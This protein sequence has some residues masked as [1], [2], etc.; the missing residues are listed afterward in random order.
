[1]ATLEEEVTTLRVGDGPVRVRISLGY[2]KEVQDVWIKPGFSIEVLVPEDA[3]VDDYI[4]NELA[5][6]VR[7]KLLMRKKEVM[8]GAGLLKSKVGKSNV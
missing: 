8:R 6:Y 7:R 1:M 2:S 5:P 4:E 3:D